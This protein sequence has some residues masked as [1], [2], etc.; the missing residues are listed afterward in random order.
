MDSYERG[1]ASPKVAAYQRYRGFRPLRALESQD[2]ERAVSRGKSGLGDDSGFPSSLPCAH[3]K[4]AIIAGS[5]VRP[6][7]APLRALYIPVWFG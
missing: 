4:A 7:E 5:S 1:P 6:D 2:G 3:A